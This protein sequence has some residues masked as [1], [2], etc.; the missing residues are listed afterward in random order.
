MEIRYIGHSSFLIK[1]KDAVVICDPYDESMVGLKFPKLE[2]DIVTISHSHLD[3]SKS[4]NV[5]GKPLIINIPGE[6]DKNGVRVYGYKTFHD[7]KNG[8]D[9]GNNVIFKIEIDGINILHCGDLA[10]LLNDEL[11]EEIDDID[12]LLVP[13]G[14]NYTLSGQEAADLVKKIEPNIVI[15]MHYNHE[16]LNQENFGTTLPVQDFLT[17]MGVSA[18][19]PIDRLVI[20]KEELNEESTKVVLLNYG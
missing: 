12:V 6:Y 17:K 15:P 4:D 5:L 16:K 18:I 7:K 13:V 3:H 1:N 20:K 14:G 8:E 19:E 9:R 11:L 2:A 10:H